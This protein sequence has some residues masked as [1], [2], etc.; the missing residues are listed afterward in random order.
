MIYGDETNADNPQPSLPA[1]T[2]SCN[3]YTYCMC[4]PIRYVDPS[5]EFIPLVII[6]GIALSDVVVAGA[7]TTAVVGTVKVIYSAVKGNKANTEKKGATAAKSA[8]ATGD[9]NK[10]NKNKNTQN[11]KTQNKN[12]KSKGTS[13]TSKLS[14]DALKKI[15]NKAENS[16]IRA[17]KGTAND[18]FTFF[19]NQ[20]NPSTIKEVK[21]GVY[22]GQDSNGLTFTFRASSK[23]GPPTIDV[24]GIEGLRKIK[25]LE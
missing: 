6:A 12:N 14:P 19:K 20:V 4:N 18:A 21:S 8:S 13:N 15:G 11:K 10:N 5:G 9:P 25:F 16:G 2:Q 1:I 24:N 17:V 7:F 22:V 3:L 23:S